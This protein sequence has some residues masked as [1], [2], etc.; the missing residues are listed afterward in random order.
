MLTTTPL[1]PHLSVTTDK[2]KLAGVE[3]QPCSYDREITNP[4]DLYTSEGLKFYPL[5]SIEFYM[6]KTKEKNLNY[7]RLHLCSLVVTLI[8]LLIFFFF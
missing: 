2:K 6:F 7:T 3:G 5:F 1:C 8:S 4:N